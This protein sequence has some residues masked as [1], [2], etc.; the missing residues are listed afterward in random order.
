MHITESEVLFYKEI[1]CLKGLEFEKG[2]RLMLMVVGCH[3]GHENLDGRE[4]ES[5]VLGYCRLKKTSKEEN[6]SEVGLS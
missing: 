4:R 2:N 1:Y 6:E 3:D 5:S